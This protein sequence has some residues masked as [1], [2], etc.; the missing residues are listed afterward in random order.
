M[1]Q[2]SHKFRASRTS[3]VSGNFMA[4]RPAL[5]TAP[6]P[7]LSS[8]SRFDGTLHNP[9]SF[10]DEDDSP[11]RPERQIPIRREP[12]KQV[13]GAGVSQDPI[14]L[15]LSDSPS[16]SP[17]RSR[18]SALKSASRESAPRTRSPLAHSPLPSLSK[19]SSPHDPAHGV[20]E[21]FSAAENATGPMIKV[22]PQSIQNQQNKIT[23]SKSQVPTRNAYMSTPQA[24]S[25]E[26]GDGDVPM[27][28]NFQASPSTPSKHAS[29]RGHRSSQKSTD[30]S[31]SSSSPL[32]ARLQQRRNSMKINDTTKPRSQSPREVISRRSMSSE[33]TSHAQP[34]TL[35]ELEKS[36]E[37]FESKL[38]DDHALGMR[39]LLQD[40]REIAAGRELSFLEAP[41][42]D[43]GAFTPWAS[44]RGV[45]VRTGEPINGTQHIDKLES[46]VSS[47]IM[48][49]IRANQHRLRASLASLAR[50]KAN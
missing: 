23:P 18:Q 4:S 24:E 34:P 16:P 27:S 25:D 50:Q 9:I 29:S 22:S 48:S 42:V 44:K 3:R 5:G 20:Q 46:F 43:K 11:K 13:S 35:E 32:I 31:I 1:S 41:F 40:V 8:H 47:K 19:D 30:F 38:R 33:H 14:D 26:D 21:D 6:A 10:I 7:V 2:L 37:E 45:Q 28:Q 36:L 12:P 49:K 15:T 39:W 17:S